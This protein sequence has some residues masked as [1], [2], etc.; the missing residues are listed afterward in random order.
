ML[1]L[2]ALIN[3]PIGTCFT[4]ILSLYLNLSLSAPPLSTM[5][6]VWLTRTCT[7]LYYF[8]CEISDGVTKEG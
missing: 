5:L 3:Q 2:H 7:C 4:F 6:A 8:S 1:T